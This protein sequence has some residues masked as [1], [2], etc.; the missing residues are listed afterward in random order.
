MG[1]GV[2]DRRGVALTAP[3]AVRT[4][5]F[6][7]VAYA[8]P[9]VIFTAIALMTP[10][11]DSEGMLDG[12]TS[13]LIAVTPP[14]LVMSWLVMNG[15]PTVLLLLCLNRWSRAVGP[16]VFAFVTTVVSGL[17]VAWFALLSTRGSAM[18]VGVADSTGMSVPQLLMATAAL[19]ALLC[20]IV[21]WSLLRWVRREYVRKRVNDRSLMLDAVWLVFASFYAVAFALEGPRWSAAGILAFTAYKLTSSARV[22]PGHDGRGLTSC[23]SSLSDAAAINYFDRLG[24]HWRYVGSLQVVT[25]PDVAHTTVQPHQLLDFLAGRLKKHFIGT[26]NAIEARVRERTERPTAMGGFASTTSSA[27]RT[28]GKRSSRGSS[29][30]VT[31][32]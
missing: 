19:T 16:P 4:A 5:V 32:C 20:G 13:T 17:I 14:Q 24:R 7:V 1:R 25:G 23:A 3:R 15:T 18:V 27:T 10:A 31:W 6:G 21:G 8:M 11:V 22:A 28:R 30:T 29:R 26:A 9:L 12:V 2:A